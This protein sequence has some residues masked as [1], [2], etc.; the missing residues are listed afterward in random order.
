MC[1]LKIK[2]VIFILALIL[3]CNGG[4]S[5]NN[6][7]FKG[8]NFDGSAFGSLGGYGIEVSLPISLV[9]F[10]SSCYNNETLIKWVTS[11]EINNDYF[12]I[13]R[14]EDGSN[15]QE[16]GSVIGAGNS[17]SIQNYSFQIPEYLNS[18]AYYRLIQ[19]DFNGN[20]EY[21][22]PI[23]VQPC[24]EKEEPS[25]MI[26]VSNRNIDI[27]YTGDESLIKSLDVISAN[28]NLIYH[29]DEYQKSIPLSNSSAAFYAVVI[30]TENNTYTQKFVY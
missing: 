28:G 16:I 5:Q 19:T 26:F 12:T 3:S 11:S 29:N 22:N 21:F 14:S 9:S 25:F 27:F 24:S 10:T 6:A 4:F 17:N 8:G 7:I 1:T 15:W 13:E 23:Y 2:S 20:F 30:K 18:K